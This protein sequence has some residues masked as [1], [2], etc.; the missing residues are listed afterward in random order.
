LSPPALLTLTNIG[1]ILGLKVLKEAIPVRR[2][3][4]S[5]AVLTGI[6]LVASQ[7]H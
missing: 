1:F 3:L 4:A 2:L 6:L 7:A 5:G